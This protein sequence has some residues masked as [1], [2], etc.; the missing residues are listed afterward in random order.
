ME[1][2]ANMYPYPYP[3]TILRIYCIRKI[4]ESIN[5]TRFQPNV[6]YAFKYMFAADPLP[7]SL[8]VQVSLL[9][10]SVATV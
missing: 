6:Y 1:I 2:V 10:F 5:L 9:S 3:Q 8:L 7:P 4:N